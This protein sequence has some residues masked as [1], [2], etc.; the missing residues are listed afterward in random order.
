MGGYCQNTINFNGWLQ[1]AWGAG[2]EFS[3]V[4]GAFYGATNLVFGQ[5]PPYFLD[6]FKAVYPKFFGLPTALSGCA[7]VVGT[8]TVTVPS[9]DGLDYGQFLQS[10][11][12]FPKG[13]V[14]TNIAGTTV[15]V[16]MD[17]LVSSG[18]ATLMVYKSSPIPAGVIQL[19]LNLAYASLVQRRWKEQWCVA[20]SLFIAHYL[21]LYA[22]SDESSVFE[23]LQTA[24][25]GE[26]PTGATPGTAYALSSVPPG[27]ALQALV[28]NGVFLTPGVDYVLVGSDITLAQPTQTHDTLYATWPVQVA[29]LIASQMNGAQ[30]AAAGLAG[31]IQTSKNVGDVSVGYQAL[32]SLESWGAWNLT[33]YGQLLATMAAVIGSG[34]MVIWGWLLVGAASH[35]AL[36]GLLG[37]AVLRC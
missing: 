8:N 17:A 31:G 21:T 5:N 32:A 25:H 37:H 19:Y 35:Y 7:T 13:T 27:G 10:M 30:I 29:E 9:V 11:G 6:D 15:T 23:I 20:M 26:V 4:C 24:I 22:K 16:S 34:P 1:N 2:Q 14:I 28:K 3:V 12:V 36:Y 18:N 33:S